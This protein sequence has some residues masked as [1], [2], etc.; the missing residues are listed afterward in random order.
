M[1]VPQNLEEQIHSFDGVRRVVANE[2]KFKLKLGVGRDAFASLK[3]IGVVA[4]LWEVGGAAKT[5]AAVASS[6]TVASTFFGSFLSNMGLYTAATPVGWVIGA[7]LVSGGAYYGV[8]RLFRSYTG[9]RVQEIPRFINT[10]LDVLATSAL[11]LLGSLALKVA[12]IDGTLHE[13]ERSAIVDYF[14]EEWGYDSDYVDH[15][16]DVLEDNTSISRLSDMADELASFARDNPD[17]DYASIQKEILALLKEIAEADGTLDE[18]EEMAI[19]RV[20]E[21]LRAQNSLLSS[22]G[23]VI[24]STASGVVAGADIV[25]KSV[26]NTFS[27]TKSV[28]GALSNKMRSRK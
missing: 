15:A 26:G 11:D 21:A 5:G 4:Q 25:G 7:A 6:N 9:S 17:C 24:G 13:T 1:N 27:N 2:E 23:N 8:V 20:E 18:R 10:G 22:A 3:A 19:Q 16:L 14:V 28:F 12:V